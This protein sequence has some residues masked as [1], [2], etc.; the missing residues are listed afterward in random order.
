MNN[1]K[2]QFLL[3]ALFAAAFITSCDDSSTGTEE[4]ESEIETH[5]VEDLYAPSTRED[6]DARFV[7]FSL[8]NGEEVSI[9]DSASANW[10]IGFRGTDIIVNAGTSGPGEGE[11]ILLDLSFEEI[12]IAPSEG[13]LKDGEEYAVS[14]WYTYTG[15]SSPQHAVLPNDETTVVL[16]TAD[17]NHHAKLELIS[18]YEGNPDTSTEEFANLQ[19]RP[20]S[21]YYTFRYAIQLEEGLRELN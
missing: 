17:D 13:Y 2:I 11:A 1:M 14:N 16:K 12:E 9:A 6:P 15:D 8:R 20:S 10:D 19:T 7:L 3:A 18:Y 21:S 5:T 4:P